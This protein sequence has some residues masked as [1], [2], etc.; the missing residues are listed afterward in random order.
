MLNLLHLSVFFFNIVLCII[1]VV[2][3]ICIASLKRHCIYILGSCFKDKCLHIYQSFQNG[4]K[5]V[6]V[7][8]SFPLYGF[9][10]SILSTIENVID[11]PYLC[12]VAIRSRLLSMPYW[13]SKHSWHYSPKYIELRCSF[14]TLCLVLSH[15]MDGVNLGCTF[16]QTHPT[17]SSMGGG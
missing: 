14:G 7:H 5:Q 11:L 8:C 3:N 12:A 10:K 9:C 15:V 2:L 17:C 6:S 16:T 4:N 1:K 13:K